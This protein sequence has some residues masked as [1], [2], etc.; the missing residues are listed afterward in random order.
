MK[1][2][3]HPRRVVRPLVLALALTGAPLVAAASGAEAATPYCGITWGSQDKPLR[4]VT[5][6]VGSPGAGVDAIT[7]VRTGRHACFDRLVIDLGVRGGAQYTVRYVGV[8]V[9]QGQGAT[10]P[11]RGGARLEIVVMAPAYDRNTGAPTYHFTNA[12]ELRNVA[13][14]PTFRQVAYGGSFEGY[15]TIGLGVRARLPMR[16][17]VVNGPGGSSRVVIDVAH[18]W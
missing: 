9:S 6:A 2:S 17:F 12:R 13:G 3:S 15:T 8:V 5:N 7:N 18:R 14:Y 16:A 1:L 10:I 11:L 4:P